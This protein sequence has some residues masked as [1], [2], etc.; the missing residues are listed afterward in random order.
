[1]AKA[2]RTETG[3]GTRWTSPLMMKS[4]PQCPYCGE[5]L[6]AQTWI[7]YMGDATCKQC[8]DMQSG[9][10]YDRLMISQL[11]PLGL[12]QSPQHGISFWIAI[13]K[14]AWKKSILS[15]INVAGDRFEYVTQAHQRSLDSRGTPQNP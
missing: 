14:E 6:D 11:G 8:A 15:L 10:P 9:K 2:R 12:V 1:M 7:A 4:Q 5:P 3:I 13:K